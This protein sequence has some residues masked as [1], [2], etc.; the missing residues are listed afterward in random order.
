MRPGR[1]TR[2]RSATR[3]DLAGSGSGWRCLPA[4]LAKQ[5]PFFDNTTVGQVAV[6]GLSARF[7][8]DF[9]TSAGFH[10]MLRRRVGDLVFLVHSSCRATAG[11]A[12]D[13]SNHK[14]AHILPFKM[15]PARPRCRVR[16]DSRL[17][18]STHHSPRRRDSTAG[19]PTRSR[20]QSGSIFEDEVGQKRRHAD[21]APENRSPVQPK[22]LYHI[23]I[24][25]L[26]GMI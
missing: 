9:Q 12:Q 10:A 21:Q 5:L 7:V 25:L 3:P 17:A 2:A 24:Y 6:A 8:P 22:S 14:E 16:I 20:L 11:E 13:S 4:R 1:E 15:I 23:E 19:S 18:F 26:L